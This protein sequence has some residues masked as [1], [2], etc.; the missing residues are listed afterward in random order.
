[1]NVARFTTEQACQAITALT[2]AR[3]RRLLHHAL[4]YDEEPAELTAGEMLF[5]W[6]A[7]ILATLRPVSEDKQELVMERFGQDIVR[8]GDLLWPTLNSKEQPPQLPICQLVFANR[9]WACLSG[10]EEFFNMVHG[11]SVPALKFVPIETF[12]YNLTSIFVE[13]S[14][15][16]T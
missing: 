15:K 10:R 8:Y 4:E 11:D 12:V 7:D 3:R 14:R 9:Q 5:L 13:R 2:P 6:T 16:M 1:M